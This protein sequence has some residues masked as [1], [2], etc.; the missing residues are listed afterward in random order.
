MRRR[1]T[2]MVNTGFTSN[3]YYSTSIQLQVMI[4]ASG[5]YWVP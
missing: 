4:V 2:K 3:D 5:N 1:W